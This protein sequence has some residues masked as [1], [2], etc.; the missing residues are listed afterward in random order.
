MKYPWLPLALGL[1]LL[2]GCARVPSG[3]PV[4]WPAHRAAMAALE[5]WQLEGKLGY[6][7]A[8]DAGSAR[9]AWAQRGPWTEVSLS[10]PFGAGSAHIQAGPQGAVLRQPGRADRHA[11]S[12]EALSREVFGWVLPARE[13]RDWVRGIPFRGAPVQDI[14]FDGQG[15]LGAL[16]QNGWELAFADYRET[17]AGFLPGR[18]DADDGQLRL[19]LVIKS[20]Q[21]GARG[22]QR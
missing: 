8:Q 15:R 22:V 14:A 6:H 7:T 19:R 20:W 9:L 21:V 1:A 11:D 17:A 3:A 5:E 18:I 10:G 12:A 13:L 4:A 16:R 2:A